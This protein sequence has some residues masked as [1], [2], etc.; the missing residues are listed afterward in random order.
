M[1]LLLLYS[2][3]SSSS[4]LLLLLLELLLSDNVSVVVA[5]AVVSV[6]AVA[7]VVVAVVVAFSNVCAVGSSLSFSLSVLFV[8][9][10][11]FAFEITADSIAE[12]GTDGAA[13]TDAD[14]YQGLQCSMK[15][16]SRSQFQAMLEEDKISFN[17]IPS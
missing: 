11:V 5:V 10:G 15:S 9:G 1:R 6:V 17:Y 14:T 7:V 13:D 8:W 3:S 16:Q 4:S 12:I 2:L